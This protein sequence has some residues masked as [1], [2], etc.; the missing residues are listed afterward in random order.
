MKT[1]YI[2]LLLLLTLSAEAQSYTSNL[3][4]TV[5]SINTILEKAKM[6]RFTNSNFDAFYP[7][8]IIANLQ[9]NVFC[10]DSVAGEKTMS[11]RL[12]F[13]L[14]K[15]NSFVIKGNE[16]QAIGKNQKPIVT[17]FIG[18]PYT[19]ALKKEMDALWYICDRYSKLDPKYK[20]E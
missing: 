17:I 13:N 14:F 12:I 1:S 5:V 9:G 15:V 20:C 6:V 11:K 10:V 4:T 8:K 19:K 3:N 16:I 7:T 18:T 2:L